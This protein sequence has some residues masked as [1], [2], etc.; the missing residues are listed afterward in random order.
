MFDYLSRHPDVL[1]TLF[2][3]MSSSRTASEEEVRK[4][5]QV[6]KLLIGRTAKTSSDSSTAALS[7]VWGKDVWMGYISPSKMLR[8]P[9]FGFYHHY[10]NA[11]SYVI[12]RQSIG[13]PVNQDIF[14]YMSWQHHITDYNCG[15]LLRTVID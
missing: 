9:N 13:N 6:D 12:A 1:G 3:D 10:Q 15:G 7:R 5:L 11:D 8:E 4:V 14:T 2:Q